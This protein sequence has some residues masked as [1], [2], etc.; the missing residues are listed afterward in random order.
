[1]EE[2][3]AELLDINDT[4]N[5]SKSKIFEPEPFNRFCAD[6]GNSAPKII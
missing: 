4:I 3:D 1:M 2:G 6:K 5:A